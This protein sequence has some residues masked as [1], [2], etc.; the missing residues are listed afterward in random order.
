[1]QTYLSLGVNKDENPITGNCKK[2]PQSNSAFDSVELPVCP[3]C[4]Y[5]S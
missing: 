3:P 2:N 4:L 5:D 1:M